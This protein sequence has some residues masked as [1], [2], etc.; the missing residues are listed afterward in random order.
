M[1]EECNQ[2]WDDL[3]KIF[4]SFDRYDVG[5]KEKYNQ[6][7]ESAKS[8]NVMTMRQKEGIVERCKYQIHLIDNPNEEPFSNMEQKEKRNAYQLSN[9]QS[10]GK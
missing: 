4:K 1:Q 6:L 10:S 8:D 5:A 2:K 3:L 7:I 9:A